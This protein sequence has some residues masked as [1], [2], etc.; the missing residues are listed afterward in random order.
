MLP[1]CSGGN[2]AAI[3]YYQ[4][5]VREVSLDVRNDIL[6]PPAPNNPA[7]ISSTHSLII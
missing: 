5:K 1:T 3:V 2:D 6:L 4:K 7:G